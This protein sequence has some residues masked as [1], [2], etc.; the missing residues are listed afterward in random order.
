MP[1]T[2]RSSIRR[3]SRR[4]RAL[5]RADTAGPRCS[6]NSSTTITARRANTVNFLAELN[7]RCSRRSANRPHGARRADAGGDAGAPR[8][9]RAAT[10]P[11]CWSACAIS[12]SPRAS[13]PA[14]SSSSARPRSDRRAA[15]RRKDFTDLH[16]WTEVYLPGAGWVGMDPTA[17]CWPAKATS[18]SPR[19]RTTARRRRS[20]AAPSRAE[21]EFDFDMSVTASH[22]DPR[23]TKP[24]SDAHWARLNDWASRGQ[25]ARS[26]RRPPRPW[27]ASRRSSRS[28]IS[29]AAEWNT[30]AVGPTK[31]ALADKLI[32]RLREKFAP[33]VSCTTARANGIPAKPCRAGPSRSTGGAMASRCGG[34]AR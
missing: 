16:A 8:P 15:G 12:A 24:F 17:G 11:G 32:R 2:C 19:R 10:A 26:A 28:T 13:S 22:E 18:R 1:R 14:T 31:R 21:V 27:A 34:M 29:K 9:A 3:S 7:A 30:D 4:S 6:R 5:S 33:A 25:R 23:I 20:R